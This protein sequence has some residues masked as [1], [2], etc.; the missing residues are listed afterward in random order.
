MKERRSDCWPAETTEEEQKDE[1]KKSCFD[2]GTTAAARDVLLFSC[3]EI[4][5]IFGFHES[6]KQPGITFSRFFSATDVIAVTSRP[7]EQRRRSAP[8]PRHRPYQ[9]ASPEAVM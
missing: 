7:A 9:I 6:Q 2:L 5:D 4:E 3:S 1:G 8:T